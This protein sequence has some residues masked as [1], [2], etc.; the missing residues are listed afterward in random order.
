MPGKF[1]RERG[2]NV[3][4]FLNNF[5]ASTEFNG[6]PTTDPGGN[7]VLKTSK[8]GL[9]GSSQELRSEHS[10]FSLLNLT[11]E[12]QKVHDSIYA[13]IYGNNCGVVDDHGPAYGQPVTFGDTQPLTRSTY[14]LI[15]FLGAKV[16]RAA[17]WIFLCLISV[18]IFLR[19]TVDSLIRVFVQRKLEMAL[20]EQRVVELIELL[21]DKIF[22]E[23]TVEMYVNTTVERSNL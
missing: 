7:K 11:A 6:Q 1:A 5:L 3:V 18:R 16:F 10:N 22:Y 2:R 4:M 9:W 19:D 20:C 12:R 23:E 14:D 15:L 13:T 8:S 17:W 21:R